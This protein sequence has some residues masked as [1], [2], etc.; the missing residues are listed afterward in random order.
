MIPRTS[1]APST[2]TVTIEPQG[3][4]Y[5]LKAT[6]IVIHHSACTSI[7]GKGYDFFVTKSGV[8]IPSPVPTDAGGY[9]HICL[10]GDFSVPGIA[11]R[12]REEQ[13]FVAVKLIGRLRE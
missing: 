3:A 4:V 8:V 1:A 5:A 10:E 7:N 13:F 9:I 6:G 11:A 12:E 2:Y